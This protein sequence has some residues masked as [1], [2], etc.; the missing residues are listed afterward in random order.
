MCRG[1]GLARLCPWAQLYLQ[2]SW[3]GGGRVSQR[4]V[5]RAR[6]PGRPGGCGPPTRSLP[7]SRRMHGGNRPPA[8]QQPRSV[9]VSCPHTARADAGLRA[10]CS[11]R[12]AGSRA[13]PRSGPILAVDVG[14]ADRA[15]PGGAPTLPL[16]AFWAVIGASLLFKPATGGGDATVY[17]FLTCVVAAYSAAVYSPYRARL[18]G[19]V[20]GT[21]LLAVFHDENF[22]SFAPDLAP[23]LALLGVGSQP[24]RSTPGSNACVS[25]RTSTRPPRDWRSTA[26]AHG[27]R[28]NC[29]TWSPTM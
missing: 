13:S 7:S 10:G 11:A 3:S 20:T 5:A 18:T 8:G 14:G 19:L 15:A 21:G 1:P 25:Y 2:R 29:T 27:S 12:A 28:V 16:A 6:C 23:F 24:T 9:R 17:T 4:C 22:P 26:N